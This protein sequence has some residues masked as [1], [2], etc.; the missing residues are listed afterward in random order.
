MLIN[1]F[2]IRGVGD[3]FRLIQMDADKSL[4]K[5]IKT[6]VK[7]NCDILVIVGSEEMSN[8]TL[9]IKDLKSD[10]DD[11]SIGLDDFSKFIE[12]Y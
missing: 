2:F 10:K 1:G 11:R 7:S 4:T 6:A 9:T 12:E 8:N 3:K 5:Q